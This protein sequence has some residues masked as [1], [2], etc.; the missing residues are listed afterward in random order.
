M[1]SQT[2]QI[3]QQSSR[4]YTQPSST[5]HLTTIVELYK[6]QTERPHTSEINS[7]NR[8]IHLQSPNNSKGYGNYFAAHR[9]QSQLPEQQEQQWQ[10]EDYNKQF[11]KAGKTMT[12]R[13]PHTYK[14]HINKNVTKTVLK[15]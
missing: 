7:I 9:S 3:C 14:S 4:S 10:E 2:N 12:R 15:H 1:T 5:N 6:K 13:L 8:R 11:Q